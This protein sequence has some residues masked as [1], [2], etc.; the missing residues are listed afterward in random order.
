MVKSNFSK[1][2]IAQKR[3]LLYELL[4]RK[5]KRTIAFP[6]FFRRAGFYSEMNNLMLLLLYCLHQGIQF[7]LDNSFL[8]SYFGIKGW[9]TF[10]HPF[11]KECRGRF[12]P[13]TILLK[14]GLIKASHYFHSGNIDHFIYPWSLFSECSTAKIEHYNIPELGIKGDIFDALRI[15]SAIVLDLNEETETRIRTML[16][17][18]HDHAYDLAVHIRRGDKR[19]E[20]IFYSVQDYVNAS[21]SVIRREKGAKI[22]VATDDYRAFK[23]YCQ[24]YPNAHITSSCQPYYRGH[25]QSRYT[26][27]AS[28]PKNSTYK[29]H[30]KKIHIPIFNNLSRQEKTKAVYDLLADTHIMAHAKA[31]IGSHDSNVYR[32]VVVLRGGEHCHFVN[33]NVLDYRSSQFHFL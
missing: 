18:T 3:E 7:R 33:R 20:T 23:E 25:Y 11:C 30:E 14:K 28:H 1:K 10:F 29:P 19:I 2:E 27:K 15:I 22:F 17:T 26:L 9:S 6:L 24:L 21:Q 31:C 13:L 5:Q 32:T 16:G 8:I 12:S 4:S